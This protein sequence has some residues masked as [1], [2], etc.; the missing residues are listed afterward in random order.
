MEIETLAGSVKSLD[1]TA[2]LLP[3]LTFFSAGRSY[4]LTKVT[5]QPGQVSFPQSV[6]VKGDMQLAVQFLPYTEMKMVVQ[7]SSPVI[8][9]YHVFPVPVSISIYYFSVC[10]FVMVHIAGCT[11]EWSYVA[12]NTP[13]ASSKP[14]GLPVGSLTEPSPFHSAAPITF[15][16]SM[17]RK[18][19]ET[20]DHCM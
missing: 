9:H 19:L 15:S 10:P 14:V 17:R 8:R 2:G 7:Q 20:Q 1:Q 18:G 5:H 12:T 13:V 6:E 4:Y 11:H 3:K 16:I